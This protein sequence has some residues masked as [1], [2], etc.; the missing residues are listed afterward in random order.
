MSFPAH[1]PNEIILSKVFA[2]LTLLTLH[3]TKPDKFNPVKI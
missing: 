3:S 2:T 1:A